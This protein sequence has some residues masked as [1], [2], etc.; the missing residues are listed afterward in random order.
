M[1]ILS[2]SGIITEKNGIRD[3]FNHNFISAGFL[4]ERNG[5]LIDPGQ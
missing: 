1:H 4:F 5:G 3:A 2:D